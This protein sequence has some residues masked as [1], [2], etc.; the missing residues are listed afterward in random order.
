MNQGGGVFYLAINTDNG[1]LAI[2]IDIIRPGRKRIAS[3]GDELRGY[4]GTDILQ[5]IKVGIRLAGKRIGD[6]RGD[7]T[8]ATWRCEALASLHVDVLNRGNHFADICFF[9]HIGAPFFCTLA[10]RGLSG[11][12]S[13]ARTKPYRQ[14]K[15][16]HSMV[17]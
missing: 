2:G 5:N 15:T 9:L 1:T 16:S 14:P 6:H 3:A 7:N 17:V 10:V 11:D 12:L 4:V 13:L 8:F